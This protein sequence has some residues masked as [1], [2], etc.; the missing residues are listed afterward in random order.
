MAKFSPE[1]IENFRDFY[2]NL[3][4]NKRK[5]QFREAVCSQLGW[6]YSTFY[7]KMRGSLFVYRSEAPVIKSTM[8]K[9]AEQQ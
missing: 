5:V 6:A 1:K 9:Y 2:E 7:A 8:D 3:G 4:K